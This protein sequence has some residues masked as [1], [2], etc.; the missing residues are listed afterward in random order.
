MTTTNLPLKPISKYSDRDV[1]LFFDR[2]FTKP[3]TISSN[4]LDSVV[5]YFESKGF[6]KAAATSVSVVLLE[7]AKLDNVKIFKLLET[8]KGLDDIQLSVVV[9]EVL[10]YNRQ[11]SSII[12]FKRD[13]Q[14]NKIESRNIIV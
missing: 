12:G 6:E 2:Y 10:N 14:P 5:G 9:A 8:L 7:Q 3:L 11:K 1:R 13:V 4:D